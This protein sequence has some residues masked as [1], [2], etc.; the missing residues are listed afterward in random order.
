[1]KITINVDLG[2]AAFEDNEDE[3]SDVLDKAI[4]FAVESE[5]DGSTKLR[6]SNGNTCGTVAVEYEEGELEE[7]DE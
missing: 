6:D 2:N 7:S 4:D 5:E 3:L 1:M